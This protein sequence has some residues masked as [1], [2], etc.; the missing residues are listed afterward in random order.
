MNDPVTMQLAGAIKA[1][2][3]ERQQLLAGGADPTDVAKG[4][5]AVVR[6]HWPKAREAPWQER[7]SMCGDYGFV[8]AVCPGDASCGRKAGHAEHEYGSACWC[9]AGKAFRPKSERAA[10]DTLAAVGKTSKPSRFGK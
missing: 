2:L 1:A 4:F 6:A 8:L 10:E 9:P 3:E 5:E 7:C